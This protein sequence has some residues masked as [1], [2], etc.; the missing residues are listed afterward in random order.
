MAESQDNPPKPKKPEENDDRPTTATY[1]DSK[2]YVSDDPNTE[3]Q[4]E[5]NKSNKVQHKKHCDDGNGTQAESEIEKAK[6]DNNN[7]TKQT[8]EKNEKLDS[9]EKKDNTTEHNKV[10]SGRQRQEVID[11]SSGST[12]EKSDKM[13]SKHI[14]GESCQMESIKRKPGSNEL[15]EA[16]KLKNTCI[17]LQQ[18]N[19]SKLYSADAKGNSRQE[20]RTSQSKKV[21]K[22]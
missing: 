21:R 6:G 2:T 20:P 9:G 11:N 4:R 10:D 22:T 5:G 1:Q 19:I 12:R 18:E 7:K 15:W 14:Q 8:H 16:R 17:A 3:K 13:D